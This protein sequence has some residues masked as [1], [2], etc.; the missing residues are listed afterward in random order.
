MLLRGICSRTWCSGSTALLR[1]RAMAEV[2]SPGD[3]AG[4]TAKPEDGSPGSS[5]W[6]SDDGTGMTPGDASPDFFDNADK[7][8]AKDTAKWR[9]TAEPGPTSYVECLRF[10]RRQ[11]QAATS[12]AREWKHGPCSFGEGLARRGLLI[13]TDY[14]GMGCAEMACHM[15]QD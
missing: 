10:A 13:S 7:G 11:V 14:S 15:V 9:R 12:L 2:S 6:L 3:A 4:R 8:S 5:A 1:G